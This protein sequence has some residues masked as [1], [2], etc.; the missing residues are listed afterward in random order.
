MKRSLN[1]VTE[2]V[3]SNFGPGVRGRVHLCSG[4]RQ[5]FAH[6]SEVAAQRNIVFMNLSEVSLRVAGSLDLAQASLRYDSF[7]NT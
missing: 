2:R 3:T 5:M 7:A 6:V 1:P 4:K